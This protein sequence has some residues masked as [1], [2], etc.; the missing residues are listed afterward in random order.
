MKGATEWIKA[1]PYAT[2]GIV[3]GVIVVL[4]LL[5]RSGGSVA[6]VDNSA[7]L[8]AA[9]AAS[10][11]QLSEAQLALQAQTNQT[12]AGVAASANTNASQIAIAQLAA[13][14]QTNADTIT[15][16]VAEATLA[17]QTATS[18]ASAQASEV[19][20]TAAVQVNATNNAATVLQNLFDTL[21]GTN[22]AQA[23]EAL[24]INGS[25]SLAGTPSAFSVTTSSTPN[26]TAQELNVDN[27]FVD[28][29]NQAGGI[30]S[31]MGGTPSY[32]QLDAV[33]S[34]I[35]AANAAR[36]AGLAAVGPH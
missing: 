27:E 14:V 26:F 9:A 18:G 19:A 36:S 29:V 3:L 5:F 10:G 22:G 1:H 17:A 6:P 34:Q 7:Q 2:G 23:N 30:V 13:G 35:Q 33:M 31:S 8:A 21:A 32:Q 20:S 4:Y 12:N 15:G 16:Q 28:M 24:S 11:N 25:F